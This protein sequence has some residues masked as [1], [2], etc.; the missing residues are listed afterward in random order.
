MCMIKSFKH[1]SMTLK[2]VS[3]SKSVSLTVTDSRLVKQVPT[4]VTVI[5]GGDESDEVKS[6]STDF[7]LVVRFEDGLHLFSLCI[8]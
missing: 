7:K 5:E 3:S 4:Y 8:S 1:T 6:S 2:S